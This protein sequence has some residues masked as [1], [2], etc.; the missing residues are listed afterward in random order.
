MADARGV[1]SRAGGR[2]GHPPP[3]GTSPSMCSLPASTSGARWH[4]STRGKW[5]TF[6]PRTCRRGIQKGGRRRRRRVGCGWWAA[7]PRHHPNASPPRTPPRTARHPWRTLSTRMAQLSYGLVGSRTSSTISLLFTSP[8]SVAQRG[9]ER[10]HA[11]QRAALARRLECACW[12]LAGPAWRGV[13]PQS[14]ASTHST[15]RPRCC[16][17]GSLQMR[18]GRGTR[19]QAERMEAQATARAGPWPCMQ[20]RLP[21]TIQLQLLLLLL[22]LLA[23]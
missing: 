10:G 1:S 18:A 23:A 2:P 21:P 16:L 20:R 8:S 7:P 22:L 5:P 6:W 11:M 15:A 13:R 3:R 9:T 17:A 14:L 4:T 19:S 12:L